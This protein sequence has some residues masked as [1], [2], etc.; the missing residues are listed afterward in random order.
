MGTS[1]ARGN[2]RRDHVLGD[3]QP[4]TAGPAHLSACIHRGLGSNSHHRGLTHLLEICPVFKDPLKSH[5]DGSPELGLAVAPN[6]DVNHRIDAAVHRGQ[7]EADLKDKVHVDKE[8]EEDLDTEWDAEEEEEENSE[9][10]D[11]VEPPWV[12]LPRA[13]PELDEED[14]I[15]KNHKGGEEAE[16]EEAQG[17]K[18]HPA[19][20]GVTQVTH[21]VHQPGKDAGQ[22]PQQAAR[23]GREELRAVASA[24]EGPEDTHTPLHADGREEVEAAAVGEQNHGVEER[25]HPQE[26]GLE[27][28]EHGHVVY[29]KESRRAEQK[30]GV[31]HGQVQE[32]SGERV[33]PDAEAEE[34]EDGPVPHQPA[35][36]GEQRDGTG[37]DF[38]DVFCEAPGRVVSVPVDHAP[39]RCW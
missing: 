26:L 27:A 34:P 20:L 30:A 17:S 29:D 4:S 8:V 9:E 22:D 31:G 24:P 32:I 10:D 3:E 18:D 37:D 13:T 14:H 25:Q 23:D 16:V 33:P 2:P 21:K 38:R 19:V 36:A 5:F 35:Q 39:H 11:G 6:Q 28:A 12:M 1:P 7:Q 15:G